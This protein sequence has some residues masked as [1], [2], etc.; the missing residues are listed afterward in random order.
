MI[1]QMACEGKRIVILVILV[2]SLVL[3]WQEQRMWGGMV[4]I[5]L[6]CKRHS[7]NVPMW[8]P[9]RQK[10]WP[11]AWCGCWFS[12][13]KNRLEDCLW[14]FLRSVPIFDSLEQKQQNIGSQW[15]FSRSSFFFCSQLFSFLK[16]KKRWRKLRQQGLRPL[17][18][19]MAECFSIHLG[20]NPA[21]V[22]IC[23][24]SK[25]LRNYRALPIIGVGLASSGF[26]RL[27]TRI[28]APKLA[29]TVSWHGKW[30]SLTELAPMVALR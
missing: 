8:M 21:L 5:F 28:S 11:S 13:R 9:N 19:F 15:C 20:Q 16:S 10:I 3:L 23:W 7:D 18:V 4:W 17:P 22:E 12:V 2:L 29:R 26:F 24:D 14:L 30:D 6:W 1:G 27:M 25:Y